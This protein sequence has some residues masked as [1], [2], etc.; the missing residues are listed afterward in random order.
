MLSWANVLR[1][2]F[3]YRFIH[4]NCSVFFFGLYS[5]L[6]APNWATF[7]AENRMGTW[8]SSFL[9]PESESW[10]QNPQN[11]DSTLNFIRFH[12][13]SSNQMD[14]KP[15]SAV[16]SDLAQWPRYR[17]LG[18]N[19]LCGGAEE[20]ETHS[21]HGGSL[22]EPRFFRFFFLRWKYGETTV[23]PSDLARNLGPNLA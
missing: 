6:W 21:R 18:G 4:I 2:P 8:I 13:K 14:S 20:C 19:R 17:V 12:R 16:P 1:D 7:G 3:V 22:Q 10:F 11:L 9:S 23:K 5:K 15:I